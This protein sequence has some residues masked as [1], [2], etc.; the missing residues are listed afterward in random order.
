MVIRS[1]ENVIGAY[2]F[3]VGVVLAIIIGISSTLISLGFITENRA[4]IYGILVLLGLVIGFAANVQGK[5]SQTFLMAGAVLVIVSSLGM[6][7]VT[8]SFVGIGIASVVRSVFGALTAMFVPATIIV[9]LKTV[10]NM[11]NI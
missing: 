10:F 11:A 4:T 1:R 6:E 2:A 5:N 8:G 9:A 3:L 7:S